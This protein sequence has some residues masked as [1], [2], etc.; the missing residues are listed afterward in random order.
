MGVADGVAVALDDALATCTGSQDSLVPGRVAAVAPL[1]MA[2]T[3]LPVAAESRAL[4]AIK[5]IALRRPCAIRVPAHTDRYQCELAIYREIGTVTRVVG[6][7]TS[8]WMSFR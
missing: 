8:S 5:V 4:P 7:E 6:R 1:V 3:A 2:A